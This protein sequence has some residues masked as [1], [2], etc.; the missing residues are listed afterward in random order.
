MQKQRFVWA[1]YHINDDFSDV[2]WTDET[3]VMLDWKEGGTPTCVNVWAGI[4]WNGAIKVC[5]FTGTMNT[6]MYLRVLEQYLLPSIN[7][8]YPSHHRFMQ[9]NDPRHT[10]KAA[11]KFFQENG[12]NWWKT[13]RQSTDIN[14]IEQ[15]WHELKVRLYCHTF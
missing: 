7:V 10:S 13:P 1:K 14:P 8:L 4:S 12:I 9:D 5:V 3:T 2:I 11:Q 15:F 6:E